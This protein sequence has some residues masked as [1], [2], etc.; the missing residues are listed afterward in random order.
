MVLVIQECGLR[1]SELVSLRIDCLKQDAKGGWFIE[2][3]RW[4]MNQEDII[5]VSPELALVI[6]KQQ[7]YI[8]ETFKDDF[9][10]LFCD[11]SSLKHN[12]MPESKI[13]LS[14]KF[15]RYLNKLAEIFDIRDSSGRRWHF[16]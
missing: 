10:Y 11:T 1:V 5:P 15:N 4:K 9:P 8:R 12:F 13:M 7:Q 16:Q 14:Y 3:T 6:Q 2:F